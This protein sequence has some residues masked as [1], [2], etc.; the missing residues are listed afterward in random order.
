M[1]VFCY[2]KMY[3]SHPMVSCSRTI[4]NIGFWQTGCSGKRWK[5][6]P[7]YAPKSSQINFRKSQKVSWGATTKFHE[8]FICYGKVIKAR[9]GAGDTPTQLGIEKVK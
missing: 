1:V 6:F 8:L 3:I 9:L 5:D 2:E 7:F 4:I